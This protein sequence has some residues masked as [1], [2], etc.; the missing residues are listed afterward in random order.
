MSSTHFIAYYRVSTVRQGAS[1]LGLDAQ[2]AATAQ[3]LGSTGGAL[4]EEYTE[5]ESGKL[6]NRPELGAAIAACRKIGATL[7]IAKLDRL[8]RN[9]A[10]IANLLES[11]VR[12]I[13]V[14]MPNAD[15]FML[16]V[17][18]A[19]A[20]EEGRRISQRTKAALAAARARGVELGSNGK[21]LAARYIDEA[22]E[23]A[24]KYGSY[25]EHL[26]SRRGMSYRAIAWHLNES[27]AVP[28]RNVGRWHVNSVYRLFQHY[29]RLQSRSD[30]GGSHM[31][32][33]ATAP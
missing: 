12:F 25:V 33:Q 10:F 29:I 15:R 31:Y 2:R 19:M 32:R 14:D 7:L 1:S 20:E 23:F 13:A 22:D 16:H 18:A 27:Q 5:I 17:Y 11:G 8:A 26:R 4:L 6:K 24:T 3:F 30:V 28:N 9:V 21:R